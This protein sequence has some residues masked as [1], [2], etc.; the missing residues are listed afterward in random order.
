ME[1]LTHNMC[2]QSVSQYFSGCVA[3]VRNSVSQ[4]ILLT[5][6]S[7]WVRQSGIQSVSQYFSGC[8]RQSGIQSVSQYFSGCVCQSGIQSVSQYFS[9]FGKIFFQLSQSIAC[10]HE[11][12]YF[13]F[14]LSVSQSEEILIL[15]EFACVSQFK[16]SIFICRHILRQ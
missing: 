12:K 13:I 3:S 14:D 2:F 16:R 11:K 4:S 10:G 8:V 9:P 5:K 6:F 1:L 15:S 7:G